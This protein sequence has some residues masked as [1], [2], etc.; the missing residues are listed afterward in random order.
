MTSTLW[1][2]TQDRLIIQHQ[3]WWIRPKQKQ[4]PPSKTCCDDVMNE[5]DVQWGNNLELQWI[6]DTLNLVQVSNIL[7]VNKYQL[8]SVDSENR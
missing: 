5:V 3:D 8:C 6:S 7:G 1:T 4:T 2:N